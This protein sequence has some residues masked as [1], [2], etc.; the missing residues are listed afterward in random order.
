[1]L[2]GSH[3]LWDTCALIATK[4][5]LDHT[6]SSEV[7]HKSQI[8]LVEWF[9][10]KLRSLSKMQSMRRHMLNQ[11]T[12]RLFR[13]MMTPYGRIGKKWSAA[14]PCR[15]QSSLMTRTSSTSNWRFRPIY[16][17]VH[18]HKAWTRSPKV[19]I[20]Q[21]REQIHSHR[22]WSS[23]QSSSYMCSLIA[24]SRVWTVRWWSMVEAL[25]WWWTIKERPRH[26]HKVG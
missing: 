8:D 26:R 6:S 14:Q 17:Q 21:R 1:M 19:W 16:R 12:C 7:L 4:L 24:C 25:K 2:E 15:S 22:A 10:H 11:R 20:L 9:S 13:E 3:L 18:S 23:V 5:R